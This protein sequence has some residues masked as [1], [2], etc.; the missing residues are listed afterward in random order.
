VTRIPHYDGSGWVDAVGSGVSAFQPGD[1]VW[2]FLACVEGREGTAQDRVVLPASH[3]RHIQQDL[4]LVEGACLGMPALTAYRCLTVREGGPEQLGPGALSGLTVLA[5][6][7]GG[8]VGNAAIQLAVWAGARVLTTVRG[9][10]Q[11][12][13]A[14]LAGAEVVVDRESPDPLEQLAQAASSGVDIV[15]EVDPVANAEQSARLSAP[16]A[17]I[18]AYGRGGQ[19]S[20]M[21]AM[22]PLMAANARY[23]WLR[24]PSLPKAKVQGLADGVAAAFD[25]GA[26][27]FGE[28]HGI[29]VHVLALERVAE[30][31]LKA[32]QSG[33]GKVVLEL[34]SELTS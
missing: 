10:R 31:H 3:V 4:P 16:G 27:R 11:M 8:A 29:P 13:L 5:P 23:Q 24:L 33:I 21:L 15:V 30:A 19:D 34:E 25:A 9:D 20:A 2:I 7:G 26:L 14:T 17:V 28:A 12:R 32:Q 18:A 22:G 6:G 1:R